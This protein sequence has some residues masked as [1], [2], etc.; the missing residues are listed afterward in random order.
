MPT[1]WKEGA[2]V[3]IAARKQTPADIRKGLYY[4]HYA[5]LT[6]TLFKLYGAGDAAQ[7]AVEVDL[8]SLPDDVARRHLEVRDRMRVSQTSSARRSAGAMSDFH[9]RY[10]VLVVVS[11][12]E[13]LRA[14]PARA[15]ARPAA[16]SNGHNGHRSSAR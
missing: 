7:A 9:I 8:D 6:G 3:R 14:A 13:P 16:A 2:R 1:R 11:D 5:G 10:V 15:P 4:P 12:L